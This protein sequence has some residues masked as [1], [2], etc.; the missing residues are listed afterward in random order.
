MDLEFEFVFMIYSYS[1]D[2]LLS[3]TL[4]IQQINNHKCLSCI[5]YSRSNNHKN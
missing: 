3:N 5:T 2:P 1:K 4:P